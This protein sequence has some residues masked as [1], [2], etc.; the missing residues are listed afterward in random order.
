MNVSS[1]GASLT[2]AAG[3]V[4]CTAQSVSQGAG[5]A[6]ATSLRGAGV[7]GGAGGTGGAGAADPGGARTR[8]SNDLL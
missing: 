3:Q 7:T 1:T 8:A 5:G 4:V 6:G 2:A